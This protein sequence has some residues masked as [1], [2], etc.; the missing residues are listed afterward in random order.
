MRPATSPRREASGKSIISLSCPCVGAPSCNGISTE[1]AHAAASRL[2]GIDW[3]E[4]CASWEHLFSGF[5]CTKGAS[6][7]LGAQRPSEAQKIAPSAHSWSISL[8]VEM[9]ASAWQVELCTLEAMFEDRGYS[10]PQ[11]VYNGED[12]LL[13]CTAKDAKNEWVFVFFSHETRV[14]VKPLRKLCKESLQAGCSH[15][16]VLSEDGLTPFAAREIFD[17]EQAIDLEVFKKQ[18]LCT[19]IARHWLVPKHVI[20][21]KAEKAALLLQL[22]CKASA[23]PKLKESDPVARYLHLAPGTVVKILRRVGTLESDPYFRIVV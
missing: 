16:I 13:L 21:S 19:P 6:G 1:R 9:D 22:G 8:S 15:V 20:L 4:C 18:E 23:L 3:Q 2:L 11:P 12:P 7:Q 14:G 10:R 5:P 17:T